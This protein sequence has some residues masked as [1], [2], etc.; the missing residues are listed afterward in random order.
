MEKKGVRVEA[1]DTFDAEYVYS[2]FT[3]QKDNTEIE[4]CAIYGSAQNN[5]LFISDSDYKDGP[6]FAIIPLDGKMEKFYIS[7]DETGS[8]VPEFQG[9]SAFGK[10]NRMHLNLLL[11]H[12]EN[13]N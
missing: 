8:E 2:I 13:Q 12:T 5:A 6:V 10:I 11:Y 9:Q 7:K 4:I 1:G 3:M